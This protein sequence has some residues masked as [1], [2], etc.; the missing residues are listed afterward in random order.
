[1][2]RTIEPSILYVGT[3]VMLVSSQNPDGSA[4]LAPISSFWFLGW[5]AMLGFDASSRTP[6]NLRR[7]GECVLNLPSSEQVDAVDRLALLT[8]RPDV[9][10][11]KR[12]LGYRY[13]PQ[14]FERAGLHP[15]ASESVRAPRVSECPIQLEAT[16][17]SVHALGREDPRMS[18][19]AVAVEVRVRRVHVEERLLVD[20]EPNRID[21]ERWHPLL[22]SFRQFYG[23]GSRL[24][25]SRLAECPESR[26]APPGAQLRSALRS[27]LR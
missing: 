6:A 1:M 23:R 18:V 17:T 27:L 4:N 25:A 26:Y 15:L 2:H 8:G 7:T 20:G 16:L 12:Y 21:P 11:H 14:K 3:P 10:L 9:P 5:T 19:P 22:M 13:E 24:Q